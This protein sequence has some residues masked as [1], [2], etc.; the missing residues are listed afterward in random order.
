MFLKVI[1]TIF[2]LNL[3]VFYQI[4]QEIVRFYNSSWDFTWDFSGI[5][6][7]SHSVVMY[8][9]DFLFCSWYFWKMTAKFRL[10]SKIFKISNFQTW[11]WQKLKK[12]ISQ[13][14]INNNVKMYSSKPS[15]EVRWC[16]LKNN[17]KNLSSIGNP[18]N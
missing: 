1:L 18:P 16:L 17:F 7:C 15:N 12:S 2:F 6:L 10:H 14:T 8:F 4:W 11:Q 13:F 3:L 5:I 9:V